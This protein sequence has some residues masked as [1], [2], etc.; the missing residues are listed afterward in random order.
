MDWKDI[1]VNP[2]LIKNFSM[3]NDIG[4]FD[5]IEHIKIQNRELEN[6][7]EEAY[8]IS[9]KKSV[10][11]LFSYLTQ[12]LSD[13]FVPSNLVVILN[14]DIVSNKLKIICYTNLKKSDICMDID[15][16]APFET[17]FRNNSGTVSFQ[18]F[19]STFDNP[20]KLECFKKIN[21]EII[22]PV[23]GH[24]GLY[25]LVLF[26]PKILDEDYT[27]E[28]IS[29]IDKLMKFI[30]VGIQNNIH[31]EHSVKDSKTGLYNHTFF[32]RRVNEELARS[33]RFMQ[34]FSLIIIDI[35]HFKNLNDTFGHLAGDEVIIHISSILKRNIREG[36]VISRFGGEEFTILLPQ[37][38]SKVASIVGERIRE[39]VENHE[40][41]YEN[42]RLK[43]TVSLGI[44]IFNCGIDCDVN[45]I[46]NRADEALYRSK[47][48]GRNRVTLYKQGLLQAALAME[49]LN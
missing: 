10:D 34:S 49:K 7:I 25:G 23:I 2:L 47:E 38:G 45:S 3:L 48:S 24:S 8:N 28:E 40:V 18:L 35:D 39:S 19:E 15:S 32:I 36:D 4:I 44:S 5:Y 12:C 17:F 13:K 42:N 30:S 21:T 6:L 37:T 33:R 1:S 14:S 22:I 41:I 9:M 43:V 11:E 29:Y 20:E 26:G 31:Y 46:L 27:L 16:L